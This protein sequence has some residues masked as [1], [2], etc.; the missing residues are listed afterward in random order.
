MYTHINAK[1]GDPAPLLADDVHQI[2]MEVRARR[3]Q[4]LPAPATAR[5]AA[6]AVSSPN[7][8]QRAAPGGTG[9]I[10]APFVAER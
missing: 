7:R 6:M 1:N 5:T 2:I 3:C 10:L 8:L 9:L 4:S